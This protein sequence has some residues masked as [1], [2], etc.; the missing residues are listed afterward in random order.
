MS[1]QN[2]RISVLSEQK[3]TK[4]ESFKIDNDVQKVVEQKVISLQDDYKKAMDSGNFEEAMK[5][6]E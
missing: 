4:G 5:I 6:K 2:Q 1:A 3:A